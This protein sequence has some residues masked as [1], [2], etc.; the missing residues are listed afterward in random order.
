MILGLFCPK[1]NL[2]FAQLSIWLCLTVL[3]NHT[4]DLIPISLC[5]L[6]ILLF[7]GTTRCTLHKMHSIALYTICTSQLFTMAKPREFT[8]Y[9]RGPP[10]RG[11][12]WK[13][14]QKHREH[15]VKS[16]KKWISGAKKTVC[17][18][19]NKQWVDMVLDSKVDRKPGDPGSELSKFEGFYWG[20]KS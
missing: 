1:K 17:T 20:K 18:A 8:G 12:V 19:F 9:Q 13:I 16:W 7:F 5:T 14:H 11:T 4:V 3:K 10:S 2:K 6:P 15:A